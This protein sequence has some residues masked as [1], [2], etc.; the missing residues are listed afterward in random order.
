MQLQCI[1]Q[2]HKPLHEKSIKLYPIEVGNMYINQIKTYN[3][4]VGKK[5]GLT[6][7][8]LLGLFGG[9]LSWRLHIFCMSSG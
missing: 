5:T 2:I 1:L 3:I 4:A 8:Q 6:S 9:M 7:R